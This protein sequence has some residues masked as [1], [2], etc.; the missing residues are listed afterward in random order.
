MQLLEEKET[1]LD[2]DSMQ[3]PR[4]IRPNNVAPAQLINL[5]NWY[6]TLPIGQK[7][8]PNCVFQPTLD[9]F[10]DPR[11]F[12]VDNQK[13]AGVLIADC[14]GVTTK[15]SRYGR[16]ELRE[17]TNG[18]KDKA[19]WDTDK[20]EHTMTYTASVEELPAVK[21]SVIV[22]QIHATEKY[23]IL[24]KISKNKLQVQH[25][26][27]IVG[28]LDDNFQIGKKFSIKIIVRNNITH[29][30]Y[31]DMTKVKVRIS[32][33]ASKCYFKVGAYVQSNTSTGDKPDACAKVCLYDINVEHK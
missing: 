1:Q 16:C 24:I 8:D 17:C 22:G 15:G 11:F 20:G 30:Y 27:K 4:N 5:K 7:N 23:L 9:R 28:I 25:S 13:N 33:K 21:P 18:G 19:A 14:G 12:F 26:G 6:L 31:D 32:S 29:I 3:Q 2:Y 10:V